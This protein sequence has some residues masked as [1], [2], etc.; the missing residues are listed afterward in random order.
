MVVAQVLAD[1]H[2]GMSDW[3]VLW[4]A[5]SFGTLVSAMI[6]GILGDR[7]GVQKIVGLGVV[8]MGVTLV[9]R[10]TASGFGSMYVWMF[11]F[12]VALALTFPNVPKALGMWFAPEEFGMANG[13]TQAGYG[14]GAALALALT[15]LVLEPVGGWRS[16]TTILGV[17]TAA[18]G[19]LWFMTVRDRPHGPDEAEAGHLDTVAAIRQVLS[20]RDAWTLAACHMLF[21]GGYIGII[22]YAP[23]YFVDIQGMTSATAG[24]VVSVIMWAYVVGALIVPSISDRVGLRNRFYVPGMLIA[25]RA[26]CCP[27]MRWGCRCGS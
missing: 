11:L 25:G 10:A 7:Y 12:G 9:M 3:G 6:G 1:L 22:G 27:A 16:L 18:I 19:V 14:A 24:A 26:W 20:I 15:P 4:A 21:L 13:V 5:I 8:L 23:T 17:V 2:L